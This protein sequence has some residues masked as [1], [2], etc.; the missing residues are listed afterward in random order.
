MYPGEQLAV[1]FADILGK[2]VM[3]IVDRV[4]GHLYTEITSNKTFEA[5]KKTMAAYFHTY[6][7]PYTIQSDGGPAFCSR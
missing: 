2:D 5:A 7:L 4:S 1:D 3:L 6:S